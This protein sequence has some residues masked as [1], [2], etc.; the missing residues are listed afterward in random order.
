MNWSNSNRSTRSSFRCLVFSAVMCFGQV[1]F[2]SQ[3]PGEVN[4]PSTPPQF[5]PQ[6]SQTS[7]VQ[8]R[9]AIA[10]FLDD[11]RA[12]WTS[13]F[14]TNHNDTKWLFPLVASTTVLMRVDPQIIH[15][16][17]ENNL[18]GPSR[19][20]SNAGAIPV[21]I[22][23]VAIL[24]LGKLS[25]HERTEETGKLGLEAVLHSSV[26]V[27]VLKLA[28]NR[29]R[30]SK[31]NGQGGFWD[32][33]RSFPSGHAMTACSFATVLAKQYP[34]NNWIKFGSYGFASAVSLSRIG[35]LN[36]FPSDVVVGTS[37]GYLIGRYLVR[38]RDPK[39]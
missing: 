36:H 3:A 18:Q 27:Q 31:D 32:G 19:I 22:A 37:M 13:P 30:P 6:T 15:E 25:H 2:A 39:K 8:S 12:L 34:E 28:T 33:G 9:N 7:D 11:Q 35:G 1:S 26:I 5:A 38:H 4:D 23:P 24:A 14:R 29:E 20:V 10:S 16:V 21:F 17:R